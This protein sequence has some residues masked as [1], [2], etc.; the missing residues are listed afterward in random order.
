MT[1]TLL[2]YL[3]ILLNLSF[4][5]FNFFFLCLKKFSKQGFSFAGVSVEREELNSLRGRLQGDKLD[6]GINKKK[7]QGEG[8]L[9][10]KVV[11]SLFLCIRRSH[12]VSVY[13]ILGFNL[14]RKSGCFH[15][16]LLRCHFHWAHVVLALL[17]FLKK[18]LPFFIFS[19]NILV[20][21]VILII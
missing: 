3:I 5:F 18:I 2:V 17:G 12:F 7:P 21:Y 14:W 6:S 9:K 16:Q 11:S 19:E 13:D 15:I 20:N 1:L 4:I 8:R 10:N